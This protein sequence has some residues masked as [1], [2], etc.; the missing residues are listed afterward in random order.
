MKQKLSYALLCAILYPLAML[1]M[2]VLYVLADGLAFLMRRVVKYRRRVVQNNLRESFPDLTESEIA[3][4]ERG[5]YRNFADYIVETVKLF[6]ISDREITSRFQFENLD[7]IDRYARQGRGVTIYFSHCFNWEWATSVTLHMP[8]NN[9]SLFFGQVYRPLR[10][11]AF[12]RL[13]LR[14][15]G[16]FGSLSFK[17]QSVLRDL[18][19]L[20]REGKTPAVGFMSDQKPSHNDQAVKLL[21]LNHPT[22]M[23]G[24]TEQLTRR[25][26]FAAIYFDI[27]KLRR[28][29]YKIVC[30]PMADSTAE[31][32]EGELTR[33]YARL[34]QATIER[35]P[36][37]WLWTHKRWKH[38]VTLD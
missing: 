19:K 34:L 22:A 13:M 15:R 11:K 8:Q 29:Y 33:R 7:L 2:R 20:R 16:R 24:G 28:G 5:F 36:D 23:I 14:L 30:R 32:P 10:N 26:D 37:N 25:L 6:Q 1:P 4:V 9:G 27:Y 18:I 21:F 17:K 31:L 38:P 35:R 12:D 3:T